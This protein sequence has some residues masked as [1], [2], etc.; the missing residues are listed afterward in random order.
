MIERTC[1]SRT[2]VVADFKKY[3]DKYWRA[4]QST[5]TNLRTGK[6]TV[7]RWGNYN[8]D[9]KLS[10]GDFSKRALERIN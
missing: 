3:K 10:E 7:M 8:F 1:L 2:L 4:T 6:N 5:I 9:A